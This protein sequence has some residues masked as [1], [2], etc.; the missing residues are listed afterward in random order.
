MSEFNIKT[1]SFDARFPNMNQTKNCW[2]NYVDYFKCVSAKGDEYAPC[3]QFKSV[4]N[5]I[6]P[7]KWVEKW[8]E[9]RE[10]GVFPAL[11]EKKHSEEHH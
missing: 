11:Y 5:S 9:Q 10:A 2:Q 8:D 7:I 1:A 4:Y 6:C 3:K